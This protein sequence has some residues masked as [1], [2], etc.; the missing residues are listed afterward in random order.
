MGGGAGGAYEGAGGGTLPEGLEGDFDAL[1]FLSTTIS[2]ASAPLAVLST[3]L[4]G[5][6][7][8]GGL[9]GPAVL[10]LEN[11]VAVLDDEFGA[12]SGRVNADGTG[13]F[14]LFYLLY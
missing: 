12:G 8:N 5:K 4:G 1:R 14:C 3:F 2:F 13:G 11:E 6:F 9:G 10:P 7:G